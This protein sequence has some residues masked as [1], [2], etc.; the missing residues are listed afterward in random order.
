MKSKR[1]DSEEDEEEQQQQTKKKAKVEKAVVVS[2]DY[3]GIRD[4]EVIEGVKTQS[5]GVNMLIKGSYYPIHDIDVQYVRDKFSVFPFFSGK[6]L[7]ER[8]DWLKEN[9]KIYQPPKKENHLTD[10]DLKV[11]FLRIEN[12]HFAEKLGVENIQSLLL[13]NTEEDSDGYWPILHVYQLFKPKDKVTKCNRHSLVFRA[14][15][16]RLKEEDANKNKLLPPFDGTHITLFE[17]STSPYIQYNQHI[18]SKDEKRA[19][20]LLVSS[21]LAI[22][23]SSTLSSGLPSYE[24][25]KSIALKTSNL[26]EKDDSS[27]DSILNLMKEFTPSVLKSLIQKIIRIQ[28][29]TVSYDGVQYPSQEVLLVS[30]ILLARHPGSYNQNKHRYVT[31]LESIAKRL[32]IIVCEDSYINS[33][34]HHLLTSLL[35]IAYIRQQNKNWNPPLCYFKLFFKVALQA[36]ESRYFYT[37]KTDK[38]CNPTL[39][40][41][42]DTLVV[43]YLLLKKIGSFAGDI[44]MLSYIAKHPEKIGK[45]S[46]KA[47]TIDMP[48]VHCIDQHCCTTLALFLKP[49][50][51]VDKKYEKDDDDDDDD[52]SSFKQV[53]GRLWKEVS[54]VNGRRD[55]EY[56]EKM[57]SLDFVKEVRFAQICI[58]KLKFAHHDDAKKHAKKKE[59]KTKKNH[60]QEEQEL[61]SFEY[62]LDEMWLAGLIGPIEVKKALVV[63]R[64]DNIHEMVVIRKPNSRQA[65]GSKNSSKTSNDFT[66]DEKE[67]ISELAKK[68]LRKGWTLQHVPNTLSHFK[69]SKAWLDDDTLEDPKYFIQFQGEEKEAKI[70]WSEALIIKHEIPIFYDES[71][72]DDLSSIIEKAISGPKEGDEDSILS[73]ADDIFDRLLLGKSSLDV[74]KRVLMYTNNYRESIKLYEI[75]RDGSSVNLSVS[76]LDIAVNRFLCALCVLYPFCI[77]LEKSNSFTIRNGPFLWS[78]RDRLKTFIYSDNKMMKKKKQAEKEEW[79]SPVLDDE[80]KP[81]YAHQQESIDAMVKKNAQNKKGNGVFIEVGL[82]KTAIAIGYISKLIET[83]KMCDYV[84]YTAPPSAIENAKSEFSRYGLKYNMIVS[85]EN[86]SGGGGGRLKDIH[87]E[88]YVINIIAH[89]HLRRKNVYRELKNYA[90]KMFFIVDE[91]HLTSTTNTIRSS[92]ALEIALL[93]WDFVAMTGTLIRSEN[94]A[95]LLLWL[96]Q[97]V[98]FYVTGYNYW[99]A[100]SALISKKVKTNVIVRYDDIM[101]NFKDEK[102]EKEYHSFVPKRLGGNATCI[103]FLEASKICYKAVNRE[104]VN[105]VHEYVFNRGEVVFVLASTIAHQEQLKKKMLKKLDLKDDDIFLISS[106]KSII[107]RPE[108]ETNIKVVITTLKHTTG[109]TLTKCKTSIGS[110]YP[111]NQCV[112]DQYEGRINRLGQLSPEIAII[113]IHCGILSYLLQNY[114]KA[115]SLS[116]ALKEFATDIDLDYCTL[117]SILAPAAK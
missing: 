73:N 59:K 96:E 66:Q 65:L 76:L 109:Y 24:K 20:L 57:E 64:T 31:G 117:K 86:N 103:N 82:G 36:L 80:S 43:N 54:S 1:R 47:T 115:G 26:K 79:W 97:I 33:E 30:I 67:E 34:E 108:D 61:Y 84:V 18:S 95:N 25:L 93:S 114:R 10:N 111:S 113:T 105:Q 72:G 90:S 71:I 104:I 42:G 21:S 60:Q 17:D 41:E 100:F 75:A 35:S 13:G 52:Q 19:T 116:M 23:Y 46:V 106:K 94:P 78:L 92:I 15:N 98:D 62:K 3:T 16:W 38:D 77:R 22:S 55:Q 85:S 53:F 48:L 51:T 63:L 101:V 37:Y 70:E 4:G 2:I 45:S 56:I 28:A 69:G 14:D 112:R 6:T 27:F 110:V 9:K 32:A 58:Y 99:V 11:K 88:K 40:K 81:L 89:D 5:I 49:H 83:G 102:E 107:L 39:P 50:S 44:N 12:K 68:E 91:F 87:I 74:L 7:E 29:K 8:L